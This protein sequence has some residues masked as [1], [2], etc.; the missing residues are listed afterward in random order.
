MFHYAEACVLE[1]VL[2]SY[3]VHVDCCGLLTIVIKNIIIVIII[4]I[5]TFC[6][7]FYHNNVPD[8]L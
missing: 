2:L 8:S 5:M 4:I 6:K 3:I 1:L 7:K